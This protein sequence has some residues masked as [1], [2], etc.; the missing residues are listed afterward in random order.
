M[1]CADQEGAKRSAK[2][3]FN[4]TPSYPVKAVIV[5]LLVLLAPAAFA[6]EVTVPVDIPVEIQIDVETVKAGIAEQINQYRASNGLNTWVYDTGIENIA[7]AHSQ[8]NIDK[9]YFGHYTLGTLKGPGFRGAMGGYD[10]C[11]DPTAITNYNKV[12]EDGNKY[13]AKLAEY[14]AYKTKV[15]PVI[16]QGLAPNAQELYD[17]LIRKYRE[18]KAFGIDLN[19]RINQVN[20]DID[21]GKVGVGFIENMMEINP[22]TQV[23][24]QDVLDNAVTGW[25]NSPGH[26]EVLDGYGGKMGIG[27]AYNESRMVITLDIC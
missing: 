4:A 5:L 9:N 23:T 18:V 11:G 16:N 10:I 14:E 15:E 1:V 27:I 17:E 13:D 12:L 21:N 25:I 7:R 6:Q 2:H 3:N 8:D 20:L 24:T 19:N 26:K 22:H